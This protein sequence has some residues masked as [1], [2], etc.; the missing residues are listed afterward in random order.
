MDHTEKQG[1]EA[2]ITQVVAD[3]QGEPGDWVPFSTISVP[4]SAAGVS[5]KDCGYPKLR[6]FLNEFQHVLEF[7]DVQEEGKPPVCY[8]RLREEPL[9]EDE[10]LPQETEETPALPETTVPHPFHPHHGGDNGDPTVDTWLTRWVYISP[11]QFQHLAELALPEKWYYGEEEPEDPYPILKNYLNYTFKKLCREG[12]VCRETDRE[13]NEEYAAF[14][15][16]LVDQKYEYIYALCK[17]NTRYDGLYWFLVDFV[18]AGEDAGKTL[19]SLFNPLPQKAD[20]FGGRIENMLYDPTTGDL[21]CDYIHILVERTSRLP[22]DLFQENCPVGF[23]QI[24][25]VEITDVYGLGEDQEA[26]QDYF[27]QLGEKIRHTPKIL[28]RLKNRLDDAVKLSL[29]RAAWN[30][31][32]AIPVYFP[33]RDKMSLLLPLALVDEDRIDLALV[34]ER[35]QSGAYQGQTVLPL[36]MAY[37]NSRLVT[38]PDSDWLKTDMIADQGDGEED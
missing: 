3:L 27:R 34:V 15:T 16:G 32:T 37:S 10:A 11:Y 19:V 14:N 30:Y 8:V 18:V 2:K 23:T 24:D 22:L 25:G 1:L 9:P 38:R 35:K 28:N 33:S 17:K 5:Y 29:K 21:S 7:R 36:A 31:K 26:R 4:L 6:G 12:K 13:R 20:Y